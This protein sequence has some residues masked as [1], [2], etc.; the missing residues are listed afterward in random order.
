M[1]LNIAR[2]EV[3]I[4]LDEVDARTKCLQTYIVFLCRFHLGISFI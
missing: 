3:E 2:D 4:I 1:F